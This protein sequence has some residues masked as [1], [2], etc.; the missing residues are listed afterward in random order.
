MRIFAGT[1]R[2]S[3]VRSRLATGDLVLFSGAGFFS[4][5]LKWVIGARWSHV[6]VVVRT[7]SFPGRVMLWEATTLANLA[8]A[9]T[10]RSAAG[11][12]LVPLSE[13]L[14]LYEGEFKL[15]VL[16]PAVTPGMEAA[17]EARRRELTGRPYEESKLELLRAAWHGSFG[18]V[19]PFGAS[20]CKACSAPSSWRRRIR[21]WGCCRSRRRERPPTSTCL[22][23]SR[24]AASPCCG[25][26]RWGK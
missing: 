3:D 17:L 6:G 23:T 19:A 15:R 25:A 26:T 8:D 14:T 21:R 2:Y 5:L 1:A 10:G 9:E 18:A 24:A 11:V 4:G 22:A 16:Q 13:R 20:A 7:P 12:Q